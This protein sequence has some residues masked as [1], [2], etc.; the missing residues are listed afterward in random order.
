M[1]NS[2]F[3]MTD[4][5]LADAGA[6]SPSGPYF[7][8]D[9]FK[10]ASGFGYTPTRGMT[11]LTGSTLYTGTPQSFSVVDSDTVDVVLLMDPSVGTFQ[12]GEIGLYSSSGVLM[13]VCVFSTLQEKVRAVGVQAGNAWKIHARLKMAQAPAI[14][15]I[16]VIN[17]MTLLEVPSWS[18]LAAPADQLSGA[19]AVIVHEQNASGDSILVVRETDYEWCTVGYGKS[20]EGQTT[21]SGASSSLTTFTHPGLA[22][23]YFETPSSNSRYLVRFPSGEIRRISNSSSTTITW[24]PAIGNVPVGKI[25]IWEDS[26]KATSSLP[27]A[28]ANEWNHLIGKLN[29][30][31]GAPSGTYTASNKGLNQ[32]PLPTLTTRPTDSQW[33]ALRSALMNCINVMTP[34]PESS[35]LTIQNSLIPSTNFM[36]YPSNPNVPGI[37]ALSFWYTNIYIPGIDQLA[38]YRNE[39]T[40][41][42]PSREILYYGGGSHRFTSQWAALPQQAVCDTF[43]NFSDWAMRQAFGNSHSQ[44]FITPVAGT[45][46]PF[47]AGFN[48]LC[49]NIGT[50]VVEHGRTYSSN[51]YGSGTS[52]G[53]MN[54]PNLATSAPGHPGNVSI[55]TAQVNYGGATF[56]LDLRSIYIVDTHTVLLGTHFF[57][58]YGSVYGST[59]SVGVDVYTR[60]VTSTY[61]SSPKLVPATVT[62]NTFIGV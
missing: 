33:A 28:S 41:W 44:F 16:T 5:G 29:P 52:T 47:E 7:H 59:I 15:M 4:A 58:N 23:V 14:C 9:S 25:T 1:S 17:S 54:I 48:L 10:V 34:N 19:N 3:L 51:G 46:T 49:N 31:W 32:T 6:S 62:K 24:T 43:F 13:A 26:A 22:N 42:A 35:A 50:I 53:F 11:S 21:D 27:V 30:Y 36:A 40:N 39:V 45:T 38:N 57:T 60:N 56:Y 20:F 55:Y 61:L 8:V 12:F 18:M 37:A 2:G